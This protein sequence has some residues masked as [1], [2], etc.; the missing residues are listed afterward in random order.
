MFSWAIDI[1]STVWPPVSLVRFADAFVVQ[2][3]VVELAT[4]Q[5]R[6][7]AVRVERFQRL[8]L[9]RMAALKLF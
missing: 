3:E 2:C 9:Y 4:F 1:A 6:A 8:L 5:V 7:F